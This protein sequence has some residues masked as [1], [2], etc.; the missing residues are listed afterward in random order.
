MNPFER[1]HLA[2]T[3]LLQNAPAHRSTATDSVAHLLADIGEID[4][5]KL[6]RPE[7][8]ASI[9]AWCVSALGMPD[10][11]A[12]RHIH[13]ARAAREF[14]VIFTALSEG[15]LYLCGVIQLAPCLTPENAEELVAAA[16]HKSRT[17]I[18]WLLRTRF[19]E[20]DA[21]DWVAGC[22]TE[23]I[24][25]ET[26]VEPK[27]TPKSVT[28][29]TPAQVANGSAVRPLNAEMCETSFT[30]RRSALEKLNYLKALLGP[31]AATMSPG[32][33]YERS[34]DVHIA[35]VEKQKF[36]AHTKPGARQCAS[37]HPRQI[38]TDVKYAVWQRDGGRCT[39]VSESGHR[40]EAVGTVEF[41]H[42]EP[43]AR[44]GKSTVDNLRLRCRAHNQFEAE[45]TFG[46]E[47]MR[48][49]REAAARKK[50]VQAP[51]EEE[52]DIISGL[53]A[54]GYNAS[55]A[56][57]AAASCRNLPNASLEDRMRAALSYFRV[58]GTRVVGG[59]AR[60]ATVTSGECA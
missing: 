4:E 31:K 12:R 52:K 2:D 53:K 29:P 51:S 35:Q 34:L 10:D 9:R 54:L 11:V 43:V 30:M 56:R 16:K 42:I 15:S 49:K 5:R 50:A 8:Y 26:S 23:R 59:E 6:Y 18:D 32:E 1:S 36:G 37:T 38:P 44:G 7:G 58:R 41:D 47:F 3:T 27:L 39:F 21:F 17:E 45:R 40:C 13:A 22:A 14:P 33:L 20:S 25:P 60:V 55:Q 46:A 28:A 24:S 19:P 48:H 57:S